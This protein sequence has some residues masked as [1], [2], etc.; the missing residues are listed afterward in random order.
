MTSTQE[1]LIRYRIARRMAGRRD[2]LLHVV[3]YVL[4]LALA[5]IS[6]FSWDIYSR[7]SI[8]IIWAIP[9][10]LQFLRYNHQNG[11]GARKRAA[12]IEGEIERQSELS[13]L[14]EEEEYLIEDRLSRKATARSF[15]LAHLLVMVP[16][17][18]IM[19][20]FLAADP[21]RWYIP[22][23]LINQTLAWLAIFGLHWL[24][25]YFVHGKTN[26]GRSLKI[27]NELDRQWH[28]SRRR[29]RERRQKLEQGDD[30]DA[31]AV[32]RV[33]TVSEQ[34]AISDEGE[35]LFDEGE[36]MSGRTTS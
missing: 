25:Y 35:L 23:Y 29:L 18:G 9:L 33:A 26:F 24:R 12:E 13:A 10:F 2:V 34:L 7:V 21:Y 30:D 1:E 31:I 15:I 19:W 17:L 28:L 4:V 36:V 27:E 20:M 6:E 16:V 3:V 5:L 11:P 14:D 32:G 8:A 22:N